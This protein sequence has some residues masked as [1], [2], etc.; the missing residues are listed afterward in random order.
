MY[1]GGKLKNMKKLKVLLA[2]SQEMVKQAVA[3]KLREDENI[4]LI[5]ATDN[6][7]EAY[8]MFRL[9]KPDVIIF[10][11]LLSVYDGYTLLDKM[12]EYGKKQNVKFI[13]TMSVT[14]DTLVNE[15]FFRGVDYLLKKPYDAN[16]VVEKIK[17]IYYRMNEI[18]KEKQQNTNKTEIIKSMNQSPEKTTEKID[19]VISGRLNEIGI[20]AKLKGY[21][22]MITAVKEVIGNDGALDAVTKIL[23]PDVA[24]IHNSTPQRVE[25]AIRHAIEVAWTIDRESQFK[26]EF[27]YL[28]SMGKQRPTNSEFLAKLSQDII[29]QAS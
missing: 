26:K 6:G 25:K 14:N 3:E 24:K 13:M 2:D 23:Y 11:L 22:Y 8:D 12:N 19:S 21:R 5:G 16:I 9:E 1:W 29:Q 20:P 17:K 10:D 18:S 27:S 7:K 15:A 28:V 4:I